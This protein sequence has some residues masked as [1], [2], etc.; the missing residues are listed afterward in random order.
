M[1]SIFDITIATGKLRPGFAR[2]ATSSSVVAAANPAHVCPS[3][4]HVSA[5]CM[6]GVR[7][8]SRETLVARAGVG[9]SFVNK[10]EQENDIS[11]K[12]LEQ[13]NTEIYIYRERI[14]QR[15]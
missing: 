15:E 6:R 11:R 12:N 10:M 5:L 14:Y 4:A 2:P 8:S 7:A 1:R 3:T 13:E 9:V